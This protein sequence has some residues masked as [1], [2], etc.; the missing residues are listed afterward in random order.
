MPIRNIGGSGASDFTDLGDVPAAYTSEALKY[1]RVKAAE[2]GVEF[3][4]F[5]SL[6]TTLLGLTDTPSSYSGQALKSLRVNA[7]ETALEFYTRINTLLGLT[8]TPSSYS[9]QTLK[10]VQVNAAENALEFTPQTGG[11]GRADLSITKDRAGVKYMGEGKL[12]T[13]INK[14]YEKSDLNDLFDLCKASVQDCV[15][16]VGGSGYDTDRFVMTDQFL[17]DYDNIIFRCAGMGATVF[18]PVDGLNKDLFAHEVGGDKH[19][20]WVLED[21]AVEG[22]QAGQAS[23][24]GVKMS[25]AGAA[26]NDAISHGYWGTLRRVMTKDCKE[27][28]IYCKQDPTPNTPQMLIEDCRSYGNG[29]NPDIYLYNIYD[30]VLKNPYADRVKLDHCSKTEVLGGYIGNG[31]L[32]FISSEQPRIKDTILDNTPNANPALRLDGCID[33]N[34]DVTISNKVSSTADPAVQIN[35][36]GNLVKV[37]ISDDAKAAGE[38]WGYAVKEGAGAERNE[39]VIHNPWDLV[40]NYDAELIRSATQGFAKVHAP[41]IKKVR[42][43]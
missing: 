26:E 14:S 41:R 25:F 10:T 28:G 7:G 17:I 5:P 27:Y 21:F 24:S 19:T 22:N 12:R 15:I 18:S 32:D 39:Y 31:D 9:G 16:E 40:T 29:L 38:T 36:D 42:Y 33:G 20:N 23:G 8:D 11:A 13:A 35:G 34:V 37:I 1:L 2:D 6:V 4:T 3:Q 43:V 30:S